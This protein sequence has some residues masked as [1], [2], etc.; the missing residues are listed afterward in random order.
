MNHS[1]VTRS[2]QN[3][4][5]SKH[6]TLESHHLLGANEVIT[7]DLDNLTLEL[8]KRRSIIEKTLYGTIRL[9]TLPQENLAAQQRLKS[10]SV[11]GLAFLS[12][13]VGGHCWCVSRASVDNSTASGG[14]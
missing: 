8:L 4:I 5:R 14:G 12:N 13:V 1:H 3:F 6:R 11:K 10:S 9:E 7:P 2:L